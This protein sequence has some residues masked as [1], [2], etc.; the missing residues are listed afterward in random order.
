MASAPIAAT[1]ND[2]FGRRKTMAVGAIIIIMGGILSATTHNVP[3]LVAARFFLGFGV[4]IMTNAAPAYVAEVAPPQWRGRCV[5]L[6][7]LGWFGGA[8]PAAA[9]TFGCSYLKTNLQWRIPLALQCFAC[10]FVLLNLWFIPESPRWLM[11][12]G[13]EEEALQFLIDYH[14]EGNPNSALVAFEID[15]WREGIAQDGIDKRWWDCE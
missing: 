14:G 3:Q 6:Y 4:A 1:I 12:Q 13:R 15:E 11:M 8:I 5:G 2:K 9:I 7:N 10:V